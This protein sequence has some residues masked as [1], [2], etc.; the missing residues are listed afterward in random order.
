MGGV[1][2]TIGKVVGGAAPLLGMIPGV[3]TIPA[4]IAGGVGGLAQGKGLGGALRGALGGATGGLAGN[5]LEAMGGGNPTGPLSGIASRIG[6]S[7]LQPDGNVDLGKLVGTAGAAMGAIGANQQR[8]SAQKY[9]NANID[10]RNQLMSRILSG[11]PPTQY[12]FAPEQ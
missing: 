11:T 5:A 1:V 2:K 12:N 7:F 3:G 8:N 4:A 9:M 6:K 10:Q